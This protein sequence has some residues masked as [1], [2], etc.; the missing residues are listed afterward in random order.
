MF[1]MFRRS[2][3]VFAIL[4][5][6]IIAANYTP[7]L[8]LHSDQDN[9]AFGPVSNEQYRAYLREAKNRQRTKWSAFSRDDQGIGRELRSRLSDMDADGAT[10]YERIAIMHAILRAIGAE[11]LS[12]DGRTEADPFEGARKR[13]R[14][15]EFHYRVDINRL[16]FFQ[17][18]PRQEWIIATIQDPDIPRPE[19]TKL[20]GDRSISAAMVSIF[21]HPPL[22]FL[23]PSGQ[24]CP[25]SPS[26]EAAARYQAKPK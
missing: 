7:L 23:T 24:S 25:P 20:Y 8:F 16:V 14:D 4:A 3:A 2:L 11:Y 5:A 9:C 19:I 18:Y 10:V 13:R 6:I 17:P 12:T 1:R 22:E 21:D 26:P 15:V